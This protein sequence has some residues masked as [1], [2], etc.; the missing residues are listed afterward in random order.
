MNRVRWLLVTAVL[1]SLSCSFLGKALNPE[2]TP[3]EPQSVAYPN[4]PGPQPTQ[5]D[6]D[7]ARQHSEKYFPSPGWKN[8]YTV[9]DYRV[10]MTW[11][12]D[13][14]GAVANFDHIIFCG[15][16]N[17]A[18]DDFYTPATFDV[19]FQYYEGHE[20][21]KDCRS[22]DLRLYEFKVKNL[23]YDYNARF[24]V[25]LVDENHTRESLLVFPVDNTTDLDAYSKKVM[26]KLPSCK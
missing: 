15:A 18:L 11:K 1:V 6:I 16:T 8:S 26:P 20:A 4:C 19:I 10:S 22:G 5:N 14:L 7:A 24:W 3:T 23:G 2:P 9:M 25:E 21:G 13:D 17:A 12:N